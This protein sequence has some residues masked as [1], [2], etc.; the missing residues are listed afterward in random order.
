[1]TFKVV[2]KKFNEGT[3]ELQRTR[4]ELPDLTMVKCLVRLKL[5]NPFEYEIFIDGQ[6]IRNKQELQAFSKG[7]ELALRRATR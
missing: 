4:Y 6:R 5:Q 3:H 7:V 2:V 1:M